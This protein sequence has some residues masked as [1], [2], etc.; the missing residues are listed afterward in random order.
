MTHREGMKRDWGREYRRVKGKGMHIGW[1]GYELV[2][3]VGM[4]QGR[5][6]E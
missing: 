2:K 1:R 3:N 5:L 4:T 6:E